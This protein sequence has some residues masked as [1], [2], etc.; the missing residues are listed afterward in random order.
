MVSMY[1]MNLNCNAACHTNTKL[2]PIWYSWC[3]CILRLLFKIQY[4]TISCNFVSIVILFFR[5]RWSLI[6]ILSWK[7]QHWNFPFLRQ[8]ITVPTVD[9]GYLSWQM[10]F[11]NRLQ[12]KHI[13]MEIGYILFGCRWIKY[14]GF[15]NKSD[16]NKH[17][18]IPLIA[19]CWL[20]STKNGDCNPSKIWRH[21]KKSCAHRT[22]VF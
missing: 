1:K 11:T 13:C 21:K 20:D 5:A 16:G 17:I 14:Y 6:K 3:D 18:R 15:V 2:F 12:Y 7:K 4:W 22:Y 10:H 19:V 8:C 9:A